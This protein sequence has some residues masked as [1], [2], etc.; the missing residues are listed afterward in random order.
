MNIRCAAVRSKTGIVYEGKSHSDAYKES[1]PNAHRGECGFVTDKGIFVGRG[2]A[3]DIAFAA[4]QIDKPKDCL[5][6]EDLNAGH[7]L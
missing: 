1:Y 7:P 2:E 4:G 5:Y 3:A 6:S